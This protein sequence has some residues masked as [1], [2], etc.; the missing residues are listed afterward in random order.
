MVLVYIQTKRPWNG[1]RRVFAGI[2]IPGNSKKLPKI[3]E[4]SQ[5][6]EPKRK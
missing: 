2:L 4:M 5:K 1:V 6:C 3:L